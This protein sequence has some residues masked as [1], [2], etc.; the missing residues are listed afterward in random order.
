M[1]NAYDYRQFAVLYVDDEETSLKYFK[2]VFADRLRVLVAANAREGYRLLEQQR[3]EIGVL[4]TD[5]RMPGEKG[6]QFLERARHLCPRVLRILVTAYADVDTAIQAVNTGA[7]YKYVTKPWDVSE[8]ETTLLRG[9]EFFI[10]QRERDQLL[11]EKLSVL[12]NLIITDRV[13]GLG[14]ISASL[15][16]HVRNALM[17]VQTFLELAPA[18]LAEENVDLDALRHPDFWKDFHWQVQAQVDRIAHML[19]E[20]TSATEVHHRTRFEPV[21]M[22]EV[23]T[24]ALHDCRPGL[25]RKKLTIENS[26]PKELPELWVDRPKFLR[27]FELL[28]RDEISCL[29]EGGRIRLR[30]RTIPSANLNEPGVQIEIEDNGPGLPMDAVRGVFDP[31]SVRNQDPQ[32]FG[33]NLMM[34]YFIVYH[35][36]GT[37]AVNNLNGHGTLFTVFFPVKPPTVAPIEEHRDLLSKVLMNESLWERLLSGTP[38]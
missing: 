16:H 20:L 29:P 24:A 17:A 10:V 5:Q 36:G 2:R 3:E 19:S 9:L 25:A 38:H 27:F 37:I 32:E 8:L 22:S 30:A 28:L 35:H 12:Q 23:L 4:M 11:R 15:G 7:I 6:V 33:L 34:C 13:I 1:K 26:I 18:K 14:M 31:F 21:R